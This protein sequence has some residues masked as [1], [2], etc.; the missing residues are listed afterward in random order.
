MR[1]N[2]A[3]LAIFLVWI[4]QMMLSNV[5]LY[6]LYSLFSDNMTDEIL[7][8]D[9]MIMNTSLQRQHSRAQYYADLYDFD[10]LHMYT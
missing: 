6:S 1:I 10:G 2:G 5:F 3:V 9:V 8:N 4:L 7:T